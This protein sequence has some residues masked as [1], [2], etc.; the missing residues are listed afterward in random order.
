MTDA[1][2]AGHTPAVLRADGVQRCF[3]DGGRKRE[4]LKGA[5][6]S[7]HAGEVTA[8]VGRSGSG[9]STLLH[10]MGLLDRPDGGEV[11][12]DGTPAGNLSERDRSF[13]RNR[14]IGFVFQHCFLL[15]EFNVL[16]NVLMPAKVA[17]SPAAWPARRDAHTSRALELLQQTGLESHAAQRPLTLSGGEQQRVAL[18]RA[19]L[20]QPKLLLC[21]EPTGNLDPET[22][23]HIMDLV[24]ELSR[25]QGTAVLVVTHD[26]ATSERADHVLRL[27]NGEV[28]PE[29]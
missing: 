25:G 8:L 9:K 7:L 15:A 14:H 26:R 20:L 19:L 6:L 3:V 29:K 2:N 5:S 11:L 17:L 13:L 28:R 18:A 1:S 22:A 23:S 21:D 4:V 10:L 24:F 27:E 16:E 12:I